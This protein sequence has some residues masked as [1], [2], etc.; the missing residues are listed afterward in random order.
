MSR[1]SILVGGGGIMFLGCPA[2]PFTVNV[3]IRPSV[4]QPL[5]L[6]NEWRG[7]NET[8]HNLSLA[9][10]MMRVMMLTRPLV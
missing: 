1:L 4:R 7:F 9:V 5:C 2:T 10:T 3:S 6:L 8:G